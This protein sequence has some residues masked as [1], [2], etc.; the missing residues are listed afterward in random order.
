M[1]PQ[2]EPFTPTGTLTI[3]ENVYRAI[4]E[5]VLERTDGLRLADRARG[6][7]IQR[8]RRTFGEGVRVAVGV[9]RVHYDIPVVIHASGDVRAVCRSIQR[10]VAADTHCMTGPG[11]V[12]VNVAIRGIE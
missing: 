8:F 4:A 7:L 11:A 6:G 3:D 1:M 5:R 9:D 2:D 12:S 10:A